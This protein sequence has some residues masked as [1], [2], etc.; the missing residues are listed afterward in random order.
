MNIEIEKSVPIP[1]NGPGRRSI[2][3]WGQMELG[4]SFFVPG[5]KLMDKQVHV[6][7]RRDGRKYLVRSEGDGQRV[8]RIE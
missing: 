4:D 2:Y 5:K 3:P 8:W 1:T 7:A 6:R